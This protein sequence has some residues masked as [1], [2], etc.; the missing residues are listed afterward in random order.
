LYE[1]GEHYLSAKE[2]DKGCPEGH[3]WVI[4]LKEAKAGEAN[5]DGVYPGCFYCGEEE[6]KEYFSE[7][8]GF[9]Y[10]GWGF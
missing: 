5:E 6:G 4:C 8:G 10:G 1:H 9:G 2:E 3:E 7:A